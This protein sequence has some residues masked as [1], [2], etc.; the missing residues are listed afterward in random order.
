VSEASAGS[1][2]WARE[3]GRFLEFQNIGLN[4]PF[5][6]AFLLAAAHG[7]PTWQ[8]FVLV[9]IAVLAARNAGHAFNRWA[10]RALDAQNPRTQHR[11][12]VTGRLS[13]AFALLVTALSAAT[14]VAAAAFLNLLALALSPV[15]LALIFGYSYSKRYTAFTTV[16]L[17]LVEALVPA[18]VFIAVTGTLPVVAV[19]AVFGMLL[20]GTAFETVHSLGDLATDRSLGLYSIPRAFG[21]RASLVLVAVFH[22]GALLL[23]GGFGWLEHYGLPFWAAWATIVGLVAYS[24]LTLPRA[25]PAI[26]A[27]FQRHFVMA[28]LFLAGVVLALVWT[29]HPTL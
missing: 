3:I 18:G 1:T 27:P 10:D 20:W 21:T 23:F 15:A 19:V 24:D 17:G 26:Q 9:V 12:L 5:A 2:G 13:P 14:L 28:I 25:L 11:A 4:L 8:T 16:Y 22:A 6:V 29:L 7:L